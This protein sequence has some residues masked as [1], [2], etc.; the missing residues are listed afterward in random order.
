MTTSVFVDTSALYAVHDRDD[1][2]HAGAADIWS[3]LLDRM[4]TGDVRCRSHSAVIVE[5]SALVQRRLGVDALRDLHHATLPLLDITWVG[6]DLHGRAVAALLAAGGRDVSLV[7]WTSFE[8]M[9]QDAM[10]SAFA[11][12]GD[13]ADQGF[14]L[15]VPAGS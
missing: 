11:F 12:D 15:L 14:D 2:R 10:H 13:F 5:T 9:R 8:M 1:A 3:N 4:G 7:D 6:P